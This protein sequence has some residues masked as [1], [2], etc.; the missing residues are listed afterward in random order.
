[1]LAMLHLQVKLAVVGTGTGVVIEGAEEPELQ[2]AFTPS[3]VITC[4]RIPWLDL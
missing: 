1:M 4:I 3:K 2:V